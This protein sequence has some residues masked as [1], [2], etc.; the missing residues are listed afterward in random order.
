MLSRSTILTA[1]LVLASSGMSAQ[2]LKL[3]LIYTKSSQFGYDVCVTNRQTVPATAFLIVSEYPNSNSV[4]PP[5]QSYYIHDAV[6]QWPINKP[7]EPGSTFCVSMGPSGMPGE[8]AGTIRVLAAVFADGATEGEDDWIARVV[9]RRKQV[10]RDLLEA[11]AILRHGLVESVDPHALLQRFRSFQS[12]TSDIQSPGIPGHFERM[13]AQKVRSTVIGN[14]EAN[15]KPNQSPE[16]FASAI[17]SYVNHLESWLHE[18]KV[19][20]PEL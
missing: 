10:Y 3:T 4:A 18:L 6:D 13:A 11:L 15:I 8:E 7:V 20:K 12:Q 9:N 14:L 2:Q 19:S 1:L 17:K 16:E 5:D